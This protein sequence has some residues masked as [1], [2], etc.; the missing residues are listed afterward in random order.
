MSLYIDLYILLSIFRDFFYC[1]KYNDMVQ[2]F[3]YV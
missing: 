3:L 2:M 1:E